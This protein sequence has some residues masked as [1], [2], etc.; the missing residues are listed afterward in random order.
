MES[1]LVTMTPSSSFPLTPDDTLSWRREMDEIV[2]SVRT[3][4]GWCAVGRVDGEEWPEGASGVRCLRP[5]PFAVP[6]RVEW[7]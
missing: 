1:T 3:D 2:I 7:E 6:L 4:A 5:D